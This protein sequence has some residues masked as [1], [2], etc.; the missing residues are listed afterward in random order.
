MRR[1]TA[2]ILCALGL[3]CALISISGCEPKL[4]SDSLTPGT[5]MPSLIVEGWL[6]G[7]PPNWKGKVLVLDFWAYWCGPCRAKAPEVVE[8][9]NRF[10][11]QD[12]VFLGLTSEGSAA[13]ND[14]REF[15]ESAKISWP[16]GYGAQP[17]FD[18]FGVYAIPTIY[19]IGRDGTIAWSDAMGGSL[20]GAIE[21]ALARK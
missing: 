7:D 5:P 2:N 10:Q 21:D 6:N 16:N 14:S 3:A 18:A 8:T 11:G 1:R 17:T 9:Y 13:L 4:D 20:D 15:V 19:V 12:V